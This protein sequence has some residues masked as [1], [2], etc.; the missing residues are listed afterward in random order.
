M[1]LE[2]RIQQA[3]ER[4]SQLEMEHELLEIEKRYFSPIFSWE[5]AIW[6]GSLTGKDVA[7]AVQKIIALYSSMSIYIS[8]AH[9]SH[10]K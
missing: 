8:P 9:R 7:T 6:L 5:P 4:K 3:K 2:R 10:N 1:E